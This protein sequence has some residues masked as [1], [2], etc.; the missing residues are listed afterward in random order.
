MNDRRQ[1]VLCGSSDQHPLLH[2]ELTGKR[3]PFSPTAAR[4]PMLA[5]VM[6]RALLVASFGLKS[7]AM[8]AVPQQKASA[9]SDVPF[10]SY[11]LALYGYNYSDTGISSFEV[12]GQGGEHVNVSS[13]Q[14][15]GDR[16]PNGSMNT[17]N[18]SKL[19]R[20]KLGYR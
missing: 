8:A 18:D 12:N 13:P 20:C 2:D 16:H 3:R 4:L 10:R 19:S 14:T 6:P 11:K 15:S 9:A 7:P 17:N 5:L 1:P